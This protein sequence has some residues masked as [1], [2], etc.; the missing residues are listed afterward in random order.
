MAETVADIIDCR[1]A[2]YSGDPRIV[3]LEELADEFLTNCAPEGT[4][5]NY[6]IALQV[7]H[8]MTISDRS[9]KGGEEGANAPVGSVTMEKEGE[10]QVKYSANHSSVMQ[11][12]SDMKAELMQTPWGMELYSFLK[13]YTMSV[14]TRISGFCCGS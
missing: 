1:A 11:Y 8:W 10:L 2:G 7:L 4:P 3:C 14:G 9:G 13:K 6:A 12:I 5:R